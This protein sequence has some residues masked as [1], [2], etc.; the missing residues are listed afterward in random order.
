LTPHLASAADAQKLSGIGDS[1][2][3][4]FSANNWP[5]DHPSYAF[6]QGTDTNVNS[7]YL[8]YKAKFPG[9]TKEFVSVS[10]AEMV[11]GS[12]NAA[13][14]ASR[15]C[16]QAS[17]PNRVVIELGGNDV[18]NRDK[19]SSTDA[20]SNMYSVTTYR[21]GLKAALDVLGGCLPTGAQVLVLSMPRVDFL[22][23]AGNAKN[24]ILCNA[25][26][27]LAGVCPIVTGESSADRRRQIG[28][29]VDAYNDGLYAEV[30]AAD[31]RYAGKVH[32]ITD[33]QG[34]L[35]SNPNT[36]IGAYQFSA[37]DINTADCFHPHKDTGQKKMACAAWEASEYGNLG[38]IATTCLH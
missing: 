27:S 5:G 7:L 13:A 18:C 26:W 35:A 22:Y 8:R 34:G 33:W 24:A 30:T 23:E 10:G 20:A 11:G 17:R 25:V 36:S 6:G 29:R 31:S 21:N 4:G 3:Q 9:F 32:F 28:A 16:A 2:S 14:Q 19:G 1:I 37:G 38:N 15:I 12:N